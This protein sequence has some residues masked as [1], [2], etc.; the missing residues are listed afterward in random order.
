MKPELFELIGNARQRRPEKIR[1]QLYVFLVCLFISFFFWSLVRLSKD[2]Y[3]SVYYHLNYTSLPANLK[4]SGYSDSTLHLRIRIQGFEFFSE[5]FL[6]KQ[7]REFDVNMQNVRVIYQGETIRG[8]LLTN[9]L[10][11]EIIAQSGF[12][13][14][15]YFVSPD[16][17]FFEFIKTGIKRMPQRNQPAMV[18]ISIDGRDTLIRR[19]DTAPAPSESV[20]KK[21]K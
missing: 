2:Y 18:R 7:R 13:S 10:G 6:V 14:D 15:G 8:Y 19:T 17:L 5:E 20:T 3:Y 11:R 4:M 21:E 9:R 12:P 16:T 1:K